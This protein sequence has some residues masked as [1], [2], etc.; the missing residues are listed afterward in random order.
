MNRYVVIGNPIAHSQ[1]PLIHARFAAL[2]GVAMAYDRVL[3]PLDGLAAALA[4]LQQDGVL[5]CNVTVPFK[6][7]AFAAAQTTSA[8]A[9]L[10]L[11]ANTL[12]F[13]AG[14]VYA[15]NTDGVGLVRDIETN[16]GVSLAGR[17]LLLIGAGGAAAGVLAPLLLAKPR[18]L[19][20]V[21][22]SLD[23]AEALVL[24]HRAHPSL[25]KALQETALS[26]QP[27]ASP[28]G[29]FDVVINASASSLSG[30]AVPVPASVL[31]TGTLVYDMMYGPAAAP[32]LQWARDHGGIGRDGL[33][34]LIEQAAEAFLLWR[35][36]R[37]PSALV[38]QEMRAAQP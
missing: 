17:D 10:A 38:L 37:P 35:G 24:R 29:P 19:V 2:T 16:A 14:Q 4:Q 8:R 27:L 34:M 28:G 23:K 26:T 18:R 31:K 3:V 15:D 30:A 7:E 33:G 13:E 6:F 20:V 25:Q 12:K 36:V 1:S 32:L 22:R 5:G 11:A 21:N 9:Q